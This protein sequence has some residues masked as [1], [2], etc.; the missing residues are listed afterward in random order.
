M[1]DKTIPLTSEQK[2]QIGL[3][4]RKLR[5]KENYSLE[6]LA[7]EVKMSV[8]ALSRMEAGDFELYDDIPS[9]FKH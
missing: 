5:M 1:T 8:E 4:I 3:K 6:E 2:K 7:A 9:G